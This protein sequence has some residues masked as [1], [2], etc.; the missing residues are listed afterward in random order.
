MSIHYLIIADDFT[1]STDTGVQLAK[2]GISV[3]VQLHNEMSQTSSLVIDTESR[4][5]TTDDARDKISRA[6]LPVNLNKFDFVIKKVDSTLRGNI[7]A[8]LNEITKLYDYDI[9]IFAPSL[10]SIGRQVKE[11]VLSINGV[12]GLDTQFAHDPVK[13]LL[14]DNIVSILRSAFPGETISTITM[15]A[16]HQ[17]NINLDKTTRLYAADAMTDFDLQLLV[18]TILK[19][20]LRV[21]W[22]GSSGL[23]DAILSIKNP[24]APTLGIVGSVSDVT[25]EQVRFARDN[26]VRIISVPIY[27][28]YQKESYFKYVNKAAEEIHTG[29]D[30][31][32]TSSATLNRAELK[33]TQEKLMNRGLSLD[34]IGVIV[35]SVLGGLGRRI[36]EKSTLSGVFITGGDTA[37]GFFDVV[38]AD[39]VNILTEIATGIPMMRIKGGDYDN[40]RVITKA[41]AFGNKDLITFAFKKLKENSSQQV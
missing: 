23:M 2:R 14:D 7:S 6:L 1:G 10:P 17:E 25:A 19:N 30:V 3:Q 11:S 31:I 33:I 37:K 12:R 28:V 4:N 16:I 5:L 41:G 34:E 40:L 15:N 22:V 39:S 36:L 18:R 38:K 24:V 29:H 13:P 26:N 8:E 9:L 35:Q 21:L 27:D 32:I 20:K